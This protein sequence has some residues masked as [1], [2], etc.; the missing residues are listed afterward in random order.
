M[1]RSDDCS[2]FVSGVVGRTDL[3]GNDWEELNDRLSLLP[4]SWVAA[5]TASYVCVTLPTE[6]PCPALCACVG[7]DMANGGLPPNAEAEAS[8]GTTNASHGS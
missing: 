4:P 2:G 6:A 3:F 1:I 5:P 7:G 8:H